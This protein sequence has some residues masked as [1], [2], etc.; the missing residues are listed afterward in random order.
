MVGNTNVFGFFLLAAGIFGFLSFRF[1]S[2][3]KAPYTHFGFGLAAFSLAFLVW[4]YIVISVP[5]AEMLSTLM[6]VGVVP[7]VAGF[8]LLV[9]SATYDWKSSNRTLILSIAVVFL[10][11]LFVLRTFVL[12]SEPAFSDNGL[13]YFNADP[14]IE[15]M[16]VL[17]FAGGFMTSLQ[18]VSRSISDRLTAALTRIFFNVVVVCGVILLVSHDDVLQNYNGYLMLAGLVGLL[19]VYLP[20]KVKSYLK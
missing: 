12:P 7:F 3:K 19:V 2:A 9:S 14:I 17:A 16:Y 6:T 1:A 11:G 18:V 15:L 10:V 5:S 8:L 4:A 20:S 13:I